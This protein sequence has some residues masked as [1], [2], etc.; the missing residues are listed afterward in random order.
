[1]AA[2]LRVHKKSLSKGRSGGVACCVPEHFVNL[3]RNAARG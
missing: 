1:M 2:D 3:R